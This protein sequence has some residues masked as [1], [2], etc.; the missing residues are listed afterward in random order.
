MHLRPPSAALIE[1]CLP[2]I[3]SILLAAGVGC[4]TDDGDDDD[5][6]TGD[7]SVTFDVTV[8]LSEVIPTVATVRWSVDL[9]D[10]DSAYVEFG[11][12]GEYGLRAPAR[13][14]DDSPF[15]ATLLGMRA[16]TDY[17]Y[18]VVV[19]SGGESVASESATLTTGPPPPSLLSLTL[20]PEVT[21]P[22]RAAGGY[23][24]TSTVP[25]FPVIFDAEGNYVWWYTHAGATLHV[26]RVWMSHDGRSVLFLRWL[27]F[28]GGGDHSGNRY[29]GRVS[30]DGTEFEQTMLP[31]SHHDFLELPS[32]ELAALEYSTR[33]IDEQEVTGDV[34]VEVDAEGVSTPIWSVWDHV[35]FDPELTTLDGQRFGHFNAVDYHPDEDV[36]FI[37]SRNFSTIFQIDPAT[38]ETLARLG[39][40]DGEFEMVGGDMEDWWTNQHQFQILGD[41]VLVFDN[42]INGGTG[43]RAVEVAVDWEAKT[44]TPTWSYEPDPALG[45][46]ALGEVER[47]PNGNTLITW[48][49]AGQVDEITPEGESVWRANLGLGA[50]LGYM[51]WMESLYVTP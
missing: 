25:G 10:V 19:E 1:R 50:G 32:G 8:E 51:D 26:T 47:L 3:A 18:R 2:W 12:D 41:D 34:L 43:T 15:E 16:A 37:S 30:L 21:D 7:P 44:V 11:L 36:Y 6:T 5:D 49:S 40:L 46:Y 9:A 29:V 48:G 23:Y 42:G 45:I 31:S 4:P 38:G 39:P 35:E 13:P 27:S 24:V 17:T 33:T 20:D 28:A 22:S 14:G